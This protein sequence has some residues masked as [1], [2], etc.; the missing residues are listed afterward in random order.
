MFIHLKNISKKKMVI[1][2][3]GQ[4]VIFF[5]NIS[6][7]INFDITASNV[8]LYVFGLYE[9]K[10]NE[11]FSLITR[12]FHHIANSFSHVLVKSIMKDESSFIYDG[13]IRIEK[14]AIKT[15]AYQKNMNILLS[16]KSHVVSQ[17]FLEI[18][19]NDVFCTHGST[20]GPLDN[21]LLYYLQTR[22]ICLEDAREI[23]MRGFIDDI[24]QRIRRLEPNFNKNILTS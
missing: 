11:S 10:K 12:Q 4:Y 20:T 9:G 13:L 24:F 21:D 7:E 19:T 16:E 1:N 15:H 23:L 18:L 3:P 17:P 22:G 14:Q 8:Y 6:G 5:Q 2:K